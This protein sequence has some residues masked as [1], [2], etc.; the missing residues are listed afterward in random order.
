MDFGTQLAGLLTS[1]ST[2][3][4]DLVLDGLRQW[5]ED[6]EEYMID[7]QPSDSS[8]DCKEEI[9]ERSIVQV[10]SVLRGRIVNLVLD[11]DVP[12]SVKAEEDS[13]DEDARLATETFQ[14]SPLS[15]C[16]PILSE[17][18]RASKNFARWYIQIFLALRPNASLASPMVHLQAPSLL[19]LLVT[20]LE[21]YTLKDTTLDPQTARL[22]SL[23]LFYATYVVSPTDTVTLK[24][25]EYLVVQLQFPNMV[26]RILTRSCTAALSLSLIRNIHNA[27][28]SLPYAS[29]LVLNTH[30][31]WDPSDHTFS[32]PAP[33]NPP[34][35]TSLNFTTTCVNLLRWALA[36]EPPFPGDKKDHRA[37]LVSEILGALY[38]IRAGKALNSSGSENPWVETIVDLLRLP[39]PMGDIR[40]IQCKTSTASLLMD[41]DPSFGNSLLESGAL[42]DLLHLFNDQVSDVVDHGRINQASTA[43]LVPLLVVLNNYV[44]V[45]PEIKALVRDCVFPPEDEA[46]FQEK[47]REQLQL[48]LQEGS[49][50]NM[51]PLDAPQGTLRRKLCRLL[52][53]PESHIKRCT[54]EL[55]WTLC[56]SNPTEFVHR[57]GFGNALPLLSLKGFAHMPQ[58]V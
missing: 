12:S 44:T 43:A 48:Q 5:N 58:S 19:G 16:P 33:W 20:M 17:Y 10:A 47:R 56:S 39:N 13:S 42:P 51:G 23:H 14:A 24:A 3:D 15:P 35:S 41:S 6:V 2:S 29:D 34:T 55:L 8:G 50:K 27:I 4:E 31:D 18:I 57:V 1:E 38:A 46:I 22:I 21:H 40:V 45:Q 26:L 11:R 28:I 7:H 52:T 53:W 54:G 32:D 49:K 9:S 36:S 30:V 37:D 25:L